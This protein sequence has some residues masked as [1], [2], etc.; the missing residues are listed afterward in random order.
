MPQFVVFQGL[1]GHSMTA[2]VHSAPLN[3]KDFVYWSALISWTGSPVGNVSIQGSV[4]NVNWVDITGTVT[5]CGG[6]SGSVTF[7]NQAP[8]G[9]PYLRVFY[10]FTSGSGSLTGTVFI[11][12][13]A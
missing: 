3:M 9:L 2:D 5:A 11:K 8:T 1:I 13:G 10:D 12:T 4:D 6:S 7:D